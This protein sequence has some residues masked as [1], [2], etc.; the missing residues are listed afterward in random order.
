MRDDRHVVV[1]LPED[2]VDPL[3][4]FEDLELDGDARFGQHADKDLGRAAGGRARQHPEVH[5]EAGGIAR[6][7]QKLPGFL[8]VGLP[9]TQHVD[10][11]GV[12]FVRL[13]AAQL[14]EA[15]MGANIH[16]LGI[17]GV[18]HGAA[19]VHIVERLLLVVHA[20]EQHALG[21]AF[22]DGVTALGFDGLDRFHG[23]DAGQ[24]IDL[25]GPDREDLGV[26]VRQEPEGHVVD[27][28]LDRAVIVF[29]ALHL[30]RV[31]AH[32]FDELAGTRAHRS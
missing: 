16:D 29:E 10:E 8:A 30:D 1:L 32:P 4:R 6:L 3:T 13:R 24:V 7:G 17:D 5:G 22:R 9:F 25:A 20:E 18:A 31:A 27:R 11:V 12:E 28:G 21:L 23:G 2:S 26:L 15:R 14:A 19:R